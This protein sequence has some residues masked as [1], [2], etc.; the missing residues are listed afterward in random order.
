MVRQRRQQAVESMYPSMG[1]GVTSGLQSLVE[2]YNRSFT[3]AKSK[4]EAL[5]KE[6][7]GLVDTSTGQQ[8]A[9]VRSSYALQ[10]SSALSGLAR[11]GLGG[12]FSGVTGTLNAGLQRE[13]QGALNRIADQRTQSRLGVMGQ[14]GKEAYPDL[15]SLM[16]TMAGATS[17]YGGAGSEALL[18]A[19]GGIAR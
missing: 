4:N 15:S 8:E 11:S 5:Y 16:S 18:T 3:E 1:S 12:S 9:D 14:Y 6:M 19:L 10:R 7:L 17:M 13:Q 2:N